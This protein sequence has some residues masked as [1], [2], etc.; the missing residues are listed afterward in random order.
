MIK[1]GKAVW[2]ALPVKQ[3]FGPAVPDAMANASV[4]AA[5]DRLVQ[6]TFG[7]VFASELR[8]AISKA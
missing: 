2:S 4:Q 8:Y 5:L 7:D 3:L 6:E 1:K